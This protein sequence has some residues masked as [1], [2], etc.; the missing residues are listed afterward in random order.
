MYPEKLLT[1][2]PVELEAMLHAREQ[3]LKLQTN[4][5][6]SYGNTL[7]SFTLN[8]VGAHKVFPLSVKTYEYG[9]T[10][11]A[12]RL[13]G[14]G[15]PLIETKELRE[16]TGY[17]C[18]FVVKGEG[19]QV[20]QILTPLEEFSSLG[21]LFDIDVIDVDGKKLSREEIG[22]PPRRC[23]LCDETAF[24]CSRSRRHS[25]E[26]LWLFEVQLMWEF[27]AKEYQTQVAR[28]GV[29][30]LLFEV[31]VTPKPGL[32]DQNNN[33]SHTD[34]NLRMFEKSAFV[35]EDYFQK[36]IETAIQYPQLK[37]EKVSE[38]EGLQELFGR[39]RPLGIEAE[40]TMLQ[41]T[42]G[43]NTHKGV[44]F[45]MGLFLGA[46]GYLYGTGESYSKER[47]EEVIKV[48]CRTLE[49][50]FKGL[51][52]KANL[53]HG[54]RLYVK[55]GIRGI[56]GE[57]LDGYPALFQVALPQWEKGVEAGYS[58]N[59]NGVLTL[60]TLIADTEDSNMIHRSN[61]ET[62]KQIQR[63]LQDMLSNSETNSLSYLRN[64][65]KDLDCAWIA[66]NISPGGSA[67]LL[68]MT[69]FLYQYQNEWGDG[70]GF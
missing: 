59:D 51:S 58:Q 66:Q 10:Q 22:F 41:E 55:H 47:A 45:S 40:C 34:M 23:L 37:S 46:L 52:E 30:S 29:Q 5:L 11:I 15:I 60:L 17:E 70:Y 42:D 6:E 27:F 13:Q 33:G 61:Y 48:M 54:E 57:A 53:S 2:T 25:V 16:H 36:C 21:R 28:L 62:M 65:A 56:R 69:Y 12:M 14:Y 50:D 4:L 1:S 32:V 67:D 7:V 24:V 43:V 19:K 3:R 20:K 26:E 63:Q 38:T 35:L 68:A 9:K 8:M 44:I 49:S 18:F 31:S 64:M 39:L